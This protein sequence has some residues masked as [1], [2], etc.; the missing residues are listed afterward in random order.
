MVNYGG[1]ATAMGN[2]VCTD[3]TQMAKVCVVKE[4]PS[5]WEEINRRLELLKANVDRMAQES[6]SV[7]IQLVGTPPAPPSGGK[8]EE[9]TNGDFISLTLANIGEVEDM[10]SS[11][12]YDIQAI[13][14]GK[15]A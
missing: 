15:V 11:V 2:G 5:G 13:K 8:P 14:N 1:F 4:P 9:Q 12:Y 10:L 6:W 7:R 3:P